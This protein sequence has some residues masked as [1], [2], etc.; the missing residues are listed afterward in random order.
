MR[1]PHWWSRDRSSC[2]HL[3]YPITGLRRNTPR[4]VH[5]P[6]SVLENGAS[7]SLGPRAPARA[8]AFP[9]RTHDFRACP[10]SGSTTSAR[11]FAPIRGVNER[12]IAAATGC[13]FI[14]LYEP[15]N[16]EWPRNRCLECRPLDAALVLDT[17]RHSP[18]SALRSLHPANLRVTV[19]CGSHRSG[20]W[21]NRGRRTDPHVS[22]PSSRRIVRGRADVPRGPRRFSEPVSRPVVRRSPSTRTETKRRTAA[23]TA[24][25]S[26]PR[27]SRRSALRGLESAAA[28]VHGVHRY[29]RR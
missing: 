11:R 6:A 3:W 19:A 15:K 22:V 8:R 18:K 27:P 2:R 1:V 21:R 25:R 9:R 28:R 7:P 13:D 26:F 5:L 20:E 12:S 14:L 23:A 16:A 24:N 29:R 4:I 17:V 10:R